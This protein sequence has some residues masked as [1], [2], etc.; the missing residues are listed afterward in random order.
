[1]EE[2]RIETTILDIEMDRVNC[3]GSYMYK[4]TAE[5]GNEAI[6]FWVKSASQIYADNGSIEFACLDESLELSTGYPIREEEFGFVNKVGNEYVKKE[7]ILSVF[8]KSYTRQR[9]LSLVH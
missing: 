2:K 8:R 3:N 1:M 7:S 6:E 4:G 5:I 9:D